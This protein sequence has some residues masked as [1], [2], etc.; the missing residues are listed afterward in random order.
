LIPIS[1]LVKELKLKPYQLHKWEERGWL[2][3]DP[4]LKDQD[5]NGQ[6]VY[7]EN[8]VERIYF[9]HEVI[10]AQKKQG[11]HRTNFKEMEEKLFEKF[12]GEVKRMENEV[13]TVLPSSIEAFQ[14]LL[15]QQNKQINA[16]TD[17]VQELQKKERLPSADHTSDFEEM[18]RQLELSE[19][20]ED[21]LL[22]LIEKLQED[23]QSL[24]E[25]VPKK[26][27]WKFWG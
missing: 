10:E 6:R 25:I 21:K 15:V 8:Q 2:G 16:L 18:K 17:M 27:R 20:R 9:I 14:Q 13:M 22:T 19:E 3:F 12:G 7:N 26:S 5:N 11:I 1:Q 4:V 24:K 23:V